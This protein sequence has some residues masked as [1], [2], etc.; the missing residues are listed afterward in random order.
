MDTKKKLKQY[1]FRH[2]T[3]IVFLETNIDYVGASK[4]FCRENGEVRQLIRGTDYEVTMTGDA[5]RGSSISIESRPPSFQKEG[6]YELLLSSEDRANN[7]SDR[8]AGKTGDICAGLDGAGVSDYRSERRRALSDG[9]ADSLLRFR[10]N[11]GVRT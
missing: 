2:P 6:I 8:D 1:Y 3:D 5:S 7:Q 10:T 4:I 11:V 9:S